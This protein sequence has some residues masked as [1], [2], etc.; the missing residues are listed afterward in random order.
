LA[1]AILWYQLKELPVAGK[2]N[3]P[4]EV[5]FPQRWRIAQPSNLVTAF[6]I[7]GIC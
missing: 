5:F 4:M 1:D 3:I 2:L 7:G 6:K